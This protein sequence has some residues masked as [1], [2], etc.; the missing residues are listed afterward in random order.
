MADP[1]IPPPLARELPWAMDPEAAAPSAAPESWP[2]LIETLRAACGRCDD[3]RNRFLAAILDSLPIQIAV[4]DPHGAVLLANQA[5]VCPGADA[6][7]TLPHAGA[8]FDYLSSLDVVLGATAPVAARISAGLRRVLHGEDASFGTDYALPPGE[9]VRWWRCLVEA[10]EVEGGRGALVAHLDVTE[11][12]RAE[13]QLRQAL[14][15]FER[16]AQAARAALWDWD[17]QTDEVWWGEGIEFCFG[18]PP[19]EVGASPRWWLRR[20]HP[21][22]RGRVR[23]EVLGL[24]EGRARECTLEC[25]FR[26][27]DGEF[28]GVQVHASLL[29]DAA[30]RP[31]RLVGAVVDISAQKDSELALRSSEER[32]RGFV[33]LS[34]EG[35]WR[36]EVNPAVPTHLPAREQAEAILRRTRIV[37]CN[38]ACARLHGFDDCEALV[39]RTLDEAMDGDPE[40]R[41]GIVTRFV[42]GGYRIQDVEIRSAYRVDREVWTLNSVVG[43]VADGKL[44]GGWGNQSDITIRKQA[45]DALR[46]SEEQYRLLFEDN[47]RPMAVLDAQTLAFVAVNRAAT[48]SLGYSRAEFGAMTAADIRSAEDAE[49]LRAALRDP[50]RPRMVQVRSRL[51]TRSETWLDVEVSAH[52]TAFHGRAAWFVSF[53]DVS[54]RMRAEADLR[55]SREFLDRVINCIGDPIFVKDQQHRRVL[56]NDAACSFIGKSRAEQLGKTAADIFPNE[57]AEAR[58]G[59]DDTML[60][61]GQE[62]VVEEEIRDAEGA[63][64]SVL[65]RQTPFRDSAGNAFVV[66][67]IQD[68]TDR[69]EGEDA[70]RRSAE[71]YRL[72]FMHNPQPLAVVDAQTAAFLAVNDALVQCLGYTRE[73]FLA[74]TSTD[75][76]SPEDGAGILRALRDP[77]RPEL[78]PMASRIRRKDGTWIEAELNVHQ[79]DFQGRPAWFGSLTDVTQRRRAEDE[80]R[81]RNLLLTTQQEAALDGILVVGRSGE[82][83]SFNRTFVEMWQIP[84]EVMASGSDQAALESVVGQLVD[85]EQFLSRV[86]QLYENRTETGRDELA[87]KD[88][89]AFERYSAP[90]L[91]EDGRYYGR[92]WYFRDITDRKRADRELLESEEKHRVLFESSQ[93]A[94][95][96]LAPPDW[97]FESCNPAAIRLFGARDEAEFCRC[98]PWNVSPERQPDGAPSPDKAREE[99]GR[100]MREG[101]HFFEWTHQRLDGT[102]FPATVLLTRVEVRGRQMLQATVRDTTELKR[103]E[104][105]LRSS[106]RYLNELINRIGD[107]LFV[108][109]RGHQFVLVNDALCTMVGRSRDELLG[110]TDHDFFPQAEADL[111]CKIDSRVLETGIED[112]NEEEITDAHGRVS[113]IA[114]RKTRFVD[115]EGHFFVVGVIRDITDRKKIENV[116]REAHRD[117]QAVFQASPVAIVTLDRSLLVRQWNPAAERTFGWTASEVLGLPCP[118]LPPA[119][120]A[121]N[122]ALM[123]K[124]LRGQPFTDVEIRRVRKDGVELDTVCSFAPLFDTEGEVTAIVG[125]MSD[126]TERKRLEMQLVQ[127]QKLESIGQ[128]AAGIAHEINT[129]TQYVGDNTRFLKKA[130]GDLVGLLSGFTILLEAAR[131]GTVNSEL[132]QAVEKAIGE[133]DL[134]YLGQEIPA[135][136]NQTLEGVERVTKIVRAMK[137]FSHPDTSEKSLTDLNKTIE[138]TLTVARNEWKYWAD[139]VTDLEPELPLVPCHAG[140]V[141]QVILN[142]V[143]N[144]AHAIREVVGDA[145]RGKG[146]ITVSTR[147]AGDWAEVRVQDTGAGIPEAIRGRIFDPFFTTKGVGKGTG[148]GLAITHQVIV[149]KHGGSIDFESEVGRGTT[150]V[151]RLPIE[152]AAHAEGEAA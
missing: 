31:G 57:V 24:L 39:G 55:Q 5:W 30:G 12:R 149:K 118:T 144:A 151:V 79:A 74:M 85:P 53:V 61:T 34:T 65:T 3:G 93:D 48:Q 76:L 129:P 89:R 63:R 9:P 94:I 17:L 8:G 122:L 87:L 135:A 103:T 134:E 142:L 4:L 6:D 50:S 35:V 137:D 49:G 11:S 73:E 67:V 64:R 108:K 145:T 119:G 88:G 115:S 78:V 41:I 47:P 1:R 51:R 130:F 80:L 136:I 23:G 99:I 56:V 92:V 18:Y 75:L 95:M 111:F 120:R 20:V 100:A 29:R 14:E 22:D 77:A 105:G 112:T 81:F 141:N 2:R 68:I 124:V 146:T 13:Q 46:A 116:L 101:S 10:L 7:R 62:S 125:V 132:V 42:Q 91:G 83:L 60:A 138:S 127:A 143:T 117:L 15:R 126:M 59:L 147:R 28:T 98:G 96:T 131:N 106:Q 72:L 52:R 66:G 54:Q 140:Q 114:T 27:A 71:Q 33:A 110:K 43:T 16:V 152:E 44:V 90:M 25:R 32:Y 102:P 84:A 38:D 123:S 97:R 150:F 107:P 113:T 40:A 139:M 121:E 82:I 58:L 69:R 26:R 19:E 133:S 128:L 86:R 148:Q 36:F 45:E 37:E 21:E 70:L 109:D 104:E